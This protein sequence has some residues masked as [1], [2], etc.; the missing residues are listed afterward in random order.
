MP[1]AGGAMTGA[2]TRLEAET[3]VRPVILTGYKEFAEGT[4]TRGF[5]AQ[6]VD[7]AMGVLKSDN[8]GGTFAGASLDTIQIIAKDEDKTSYI[9][10][11]PEE[12]CILGSKNVKIGN[13]VSPSKDSDAVPKSYV[14]AHSS[15]KNNPHRVTAE[16]IGAA[17]GTKLLSTKNCPYSYGQVLVVCGGGDTVAQMGF[18]YSGDECKVRWGNPS[19]LGQG[20]WT[21]WTNLITGR[22]IANQSVNS[23]KF[24]GTRDWNSYNLKD[25]KLTWSEETP[26]EQG[27]ICWLYQ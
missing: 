14:D 19:P 10:L 20:V 24:A 6:G 17:I 15:D 25:E 11:N 5:Y 3:G 8:S 21:D 2:I 4:M 23:A 12:V 9:T 26:T 13:V 27:T 18:P 16:Q 1:L 22:T 7:P